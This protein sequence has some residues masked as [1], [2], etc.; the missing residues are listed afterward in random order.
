MQPFVSLLV[1][2]LIL[3][4]PTH[5]AT[6]AEE[7][8]RY[9]QIHLQVERSRPVDNDRMQAVFSLTA[10]D[11][12]AARLADRINRNMDGALKT[13]KTRPKIEVRTGNYQTHPVYGKDKIRRWR[14]T[15]ELIL[16]GTDFAELGTLIGQLQERLQ[17]TSINFSVSP[18][19]RAAVEDELIVQALEAFKQRGELVRKQLAAKGYRLVDV[20]INTPS[21]GEPVPMMRAATMEMATPSVAPP[22]LEAGTSAL[23]V[24]VSGIIELQ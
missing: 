1:I 8:L 11:D 6:A 5:T 10:E 17:V 20:S 18:M 23:T 15:Q 13:A 7:T 16:E 24:N 14:A 2:A 19:R 12:N 4:L 9:N 3:V 22:A 21:G